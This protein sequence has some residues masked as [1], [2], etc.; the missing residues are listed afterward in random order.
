MFSYLLYRSDAGLISFIDMYPESCWLAFLIAVEK[1]R[2][3]VYV[4]EAEMPFVRTAFR[5]SYS[6][7]I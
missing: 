2:A 4:S 3:P 1:K 5:I 6:P 7:A